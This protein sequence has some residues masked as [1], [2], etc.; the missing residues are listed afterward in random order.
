MAINTGEPR[1]AM[2]RV[3]F[4]SNDPLKAL[5]DVRTVRGYLDQREIDFVKWARRAG[6]SWAE[7]AASVGTTR[8]AA[9]E[10]W[11]EVDVPADQ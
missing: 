5:G 2:D 8:Q 11:Q 3:M 4:R 9:W 6:K 10:R 7:I 1:R